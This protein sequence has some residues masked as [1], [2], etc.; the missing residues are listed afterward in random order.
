MELKHVPCDYFK[1]H[2]GESWQLLIA[3]ISDAQGILPKV[4]VVKYTVKRAHVEVL[5]LVCTENFVYSKT[6]DILAR[7]G[8]WYGS[9][10]CSVQSRH[11]PC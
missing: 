10:T 11:S 4:E 1:H 2:L 9:Y 6:L 7:G 5:V 8:P 3:H